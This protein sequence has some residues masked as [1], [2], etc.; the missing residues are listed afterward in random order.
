MRLS[1]GPCGATGLAVNDRQMAVWAIS[2]ATCSELVHS[3]MEI[4]NQESTSSD[5]HKEESS[6]RIKSDLKDRKII[7]DFLSLAID[8]LYP[9]QHPDGKLLNTITGEMAPPEMNIDNAVEIELSIMEEFQNSCPQGFHN[10]IPNDL[11]PW[12]SE[13]TSG[14][15]G[16]KGVW[17]M[18]EALGSYPV[19]VTSPFSTAPKLIPQFIRQPCLTPL[20]TCA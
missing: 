11:F 14:G 3:L 12:R 13:K 10:R 1:H 8:P 6:K 7:R 16:G 5:F 17:S 4:R 20:G 2:F 18:Q 15:R 9:E 19:P